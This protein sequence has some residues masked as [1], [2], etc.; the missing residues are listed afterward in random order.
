[1]DMPTPCP[2][3]GDVVELCDMVSHPNEYKTLVCEYCHDKIEDDNNRGNVNDDFG[4][5]IDWKYDTEDCSLN[6]N[7]NGEHL[8]SWYC[9]D[10]AEDV[11]IGFMK[12]WNKAQSLAKG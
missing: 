8:T 4:N 2:S 12:I 9:E 10:S 7:V 3:C 11:F 1:M 6:I 5:L